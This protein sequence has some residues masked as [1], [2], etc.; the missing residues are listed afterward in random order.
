ML[1][2]GVLKKER[3]KKRKMKQ[4]KKREK[5]FKKGERL[6]APDSLRGSVVLTFEEQN[7]KIP[8]VH[9]NHP[10]EAIWL[11]VFNVL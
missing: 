9:I 3:C 5:I 4:R 1:L 2:I 8:S 11:Y 6:M 10:K 7:H